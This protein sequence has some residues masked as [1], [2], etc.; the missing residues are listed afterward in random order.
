MANMT[1]VLPFE[2]T[3]NSV[4]YSGTVL[5]VPPVLANG[6]VAMVMWTNDSLSFVT[7]KGRGTFV[8]ATAT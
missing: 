4:K 2:V 7:K 5:N 8:E 1:V 3:V 6:M